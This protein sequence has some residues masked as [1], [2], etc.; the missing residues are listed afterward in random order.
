MTTNELI[1]LAEQGK[2][3]IHKTQRQ[4]GRKSVWDYKNEKYNTVIYK[5]FFY[6]AKTEDM[7]ENASY[8]I[9]SKDYKMLEK[10][11]KTNN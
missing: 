7:P 9:T 5:R 11:C 8:K 4:D 10:I 3:K 2:L 6:G 1:E